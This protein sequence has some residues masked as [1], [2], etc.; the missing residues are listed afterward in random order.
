MKQYITADQLKELDSMKY[1]N[2][3]ETLESSGA[4][5]EVLEMGGQYLATYITIGIM[6]ELLFDITKTET[7]QFEISGIH[8][9]D[10]CDALFAAIKEVL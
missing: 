2:L 3:I 6:I 4:P 7:W 1:K 9:D 10:I 8:K 5:F